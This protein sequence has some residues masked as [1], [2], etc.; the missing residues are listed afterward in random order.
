MTPKRVLHCHSSF[1]PGGKEL[2]TATLVNAFGGSGRHTIWTAPG[3]ARTA[4]HVFAPHSL[5]DFADDAPALTGRPGVARYR[6]LARFLQGFDLVL[7]YNWGAMDVVA[8][9]RLFPAGCPPLIHHE[10][11]FNADEAV[12]LKLRRNLFRRAVLG[13]AEKLIVPSQCLADIAV[14]HWGQRAEQVSLIPNGV[15][16]LHFRPSAPQAKT[17]PVTIGA[18]GGLRPVKNFGRLIR[19]FAQL[20]ADARLIIF[21]EGPDRAALLALSQQL[22]VVDRVALPGHVQDMSVALREMDVFAL[23]SDTEQAPISVL[24]AMASGLP[25][26]ATDVGDVRTMVSPENQAFIVPRTDMGAYTAALAEL[27]ANAD[28]RR[29]LGQA[30]RLRVEGR[31]DVRMM[32]SHYAQA[33]GLPDPT[34]S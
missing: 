20:R 32:I 10:D 9:R 29:Q 21:G 3:A 23:S 26:L 11:G 33:Y 5:V 24:E 1:S 30:N 22:G 31:Y 34:A 8:A 13:T 15:D 12:R 19:A 27:V 16:V 7:T 28:C 18:I 4:A 6:A 2:R 25:V 17:G 14:A